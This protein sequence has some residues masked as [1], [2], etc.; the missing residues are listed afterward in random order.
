VE[1]ERS[2][3]WFPAKRYGWGW[4]PPVRWQGWGV[5]IVYFASIVLAIRYFPP[6]SDITSFLALL[7]LATLVLIAIVAWKGEK[8]VGWRWDD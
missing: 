6:R 2:D 3:Y 4:G 8:P 5:L 1:Q 7:A